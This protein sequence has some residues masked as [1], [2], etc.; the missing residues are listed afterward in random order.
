VFIGE[1]EHSVDEK[2]RLVLPAKFR[3]RLADGCVVTR[4]QEGCLYVLPRAEWQTMADEVSRLPLTDRRGRNWGRI[5]F[6]FSE[7]LSLDK[8]GR[9]MLPAKLRQWAGID[10]DVAVVGVN[11]RVELWEPSA[12][13]AFEAAA[14]DQYVNT[15]E[16]I[17]DT[18]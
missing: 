6:G 7:E 8:Q 14:D 15:E 4:G 11:T 12:W 17:G 9:V 3:A 5:F 16:R 2:G 18:L 1:Y 10:K 13:A